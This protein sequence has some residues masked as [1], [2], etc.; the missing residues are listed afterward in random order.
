MS[1]LF[2]ATD[3][4]LLILRVGTGV[5]FMPHGYPKMTGR[6]TKGKGGRDHLTQSLA[7]MGL[8]FPFAFAVLVGASEFFGGLL[9]ILGLQTRW[10]ALALAFVM[11]VATGRVLAQRGFVGEADFPFSLLVAVLALA[12]LG[13]GTISVEQLFLAVK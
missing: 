5:I 9:L 13:G 10:A 11:L 4:A 1:D 2:S 7:Q 3:L 12:L 6:G 8:P